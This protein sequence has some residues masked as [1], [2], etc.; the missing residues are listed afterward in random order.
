MQP[1]GGEFRANREVD[2][3]RWV[4]MGELAGLLS[5]DRDRA[6]LASFAP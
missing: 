1:T 4:A 2:E 3:S 6:V 5:Y